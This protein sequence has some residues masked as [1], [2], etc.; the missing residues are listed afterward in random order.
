MDNR[1]SNLRLLKFIKD[2]GASARIGVPMDFFS[3]SYIN[4]LL[5][6]SR[7]PDLDDLVD[8]DKPRKDPNRLGK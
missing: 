7:A 3:C 6:T 1:P 4:F 8:I 5:N 2:L